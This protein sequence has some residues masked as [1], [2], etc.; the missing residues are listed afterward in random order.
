MYTG[1]WVVVLVD[2][3][4]MAVWMSIALVKNCEFIYGQ[5]RHIFWGIP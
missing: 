5:S 3:E 4:M 1:S 2:D